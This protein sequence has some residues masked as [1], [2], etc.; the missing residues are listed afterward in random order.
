MH[1]SAGVDLAD[2]GTHRSVCQRPWI[3]A[4][5]VVIDLA[6]LRALGAAACRECLRRGESVEAAAPPSA[7]FVPS[8]PY[9]APRATKTLTPDQ[10]RIVS[11]S[12][13]GDD[14]GE[15]EGWVS[16]DAALRDL[17]TIEGASVVRGVDYEPK[18]AMGTATD[19]APSAVRAV[20]RVYAV[21]VARERACLE[22]RVFPAANGAREVRIPGPA[23]LRA[24]MLLIAGKSW[25]LLAEAMERREVI[26]TE[27]QWQIVVNEVRERMHRELAGKGLVPEASR[28]IPYDAVRGLAPIADILGVTPRTVA[29]YVKNSENT[30][31]RRTAEGRL[32]LY[33]TR[34]TELREWMSRTRGPWTWGLIEGA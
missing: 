2:R 3:E 24:T 26:A 30:P 4:A 1:L 31:I 28:R 16:V 9:R 10:A 5:R 15:R 8:G 33:W 25:P 7:P 29:E 11:R 12:A 21:L 22:P 20:D 14:G 19:H 27:R 6:S 13:L 23:R 17:A 32:L 18:G 34:E